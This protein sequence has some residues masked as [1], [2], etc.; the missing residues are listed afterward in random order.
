[1]VPLSTDRHGVLRIGRGARIEDW[2]VKMRRLPSSDM[3]DNTL[4]RRALRKDEVE[5]L[6]MTLVRF[7]KNASR[8]PVRGALYTAR[9]RQQVLANRRALSH[10]PARSQKLIESVAARQLEFIASAR[11]LLIQRAQHVVEGHGDLRP[12]HV[13][14]GPPLTVIDCLEFDRHLRLLDPLE[15]LAFLALEIERFGHPS[16]GLEVVRR[17]SLA[18]GQCVTDA[19]VHFYMSHRAATRAKLAAWHIGDPQF[20]DPRPW[21]ARAH[22]YLRD[23]LRHAQQAQRFAQDAEL[24]SRPVAAA[25]AQGEA[26]REFRSSSV[27]TPVQ[28]KGQSTAG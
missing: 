24:I 22:S 8:N 14:L 26:S 27:P 23:A 13:C 7:F 2:L 1:M 4:A 20:P 16:L 5:A 25:S 6:V 18:S 10:L 3:L 15:E 21:A 12:E 11:E 28:T 19:V 9:L 17:F